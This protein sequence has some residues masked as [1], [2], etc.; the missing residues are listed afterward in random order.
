MLSLVLPRVPLWY[1]NIN[2]FLFRLDR[3]SLILVPTNPRLTTRCR[4]TLNPFG[5]RDSHS[6]MLL[7]PPG[8][9][10]PIGPLDFT[11]QLLP[12]R[13]ALLP[14]YNQRLHSKVSAAGLAPGIFE[15]L[16][17]GG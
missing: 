4:G 10:I 11:A 9:A 12:N 6:T 2:R 14:D 15:A 3:L 1:R 13:N 7:L 8:S 17:L 5:G 16:S